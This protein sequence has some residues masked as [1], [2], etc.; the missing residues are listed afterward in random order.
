MCLDNRIDPTWDFIEKIMYYHEF[1]NLTE[2]ENYIITHHHRLYEQIKNI[3]S[4]ND[5][6]NRKDMNMF[7]CYLSIMVNK[8]MKI[9]NIQNI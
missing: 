9:N 3:V 5:F 2:L 1:N 6:F 4:M 7:D 8:L